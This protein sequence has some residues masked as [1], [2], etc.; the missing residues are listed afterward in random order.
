MAILLWKSPV[1][2]A[3]SFPG[4]IMGRLYL[5]RP[6]NSR[7]CWLG[8]CA[9]VNLSIEPCNRLSNSTVEYFMV[10]NRVDIGNAIGHDE[11]D[12]RSRDRRGYHREGKRSRQQILNHVY[13]Y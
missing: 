11:G 4:K 5:F 8:Y 6:A 9:S 10:D 13:V 3:D 1:T 12:P 7:Q 2:I